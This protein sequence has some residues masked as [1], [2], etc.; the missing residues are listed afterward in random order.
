MK[1]L[2]I[3]SLEVGKKM[4]TREKALHCAAAM[5]H[6]LLMHRW[7]K[8]GNEREVYGLSRKQYYS[9]GLNLIRQLDAC[10]TDEARRL[11]M[12]RSR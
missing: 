4:T 10:K 12:G 6:T 1:R 3:S 9:G 5:D 2:N 7:P 11:L 8:D